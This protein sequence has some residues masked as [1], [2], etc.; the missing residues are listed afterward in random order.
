MEEGMSGYGVMG[1]GTR[2]RH[3]IRQHFVVMATRNNRS[4]YISDRTYSTAL[5]NS[6]NNFAVLHRDDKNVPSTSHRHNGWHNGRDILFFL[7]DQ[8]ISRECRYTF[9]I[10]CRCVK[11]MGCPFPLFFL[12]LSRL[13]ETND[14]RERFSIIGNDVGNFVGIAQCIINKSFFL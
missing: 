13:R 8:G 11:T 5:S 6:H 12:A 2:L 4:S 9:S 14:A 7:F 3:F 1:G 10:N